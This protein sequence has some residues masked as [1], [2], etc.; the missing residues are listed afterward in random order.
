[1]GSERARGEG[2]VTSTARRIRGE[3]VAAFGRVMSVIATPVALVIE[4]SGE[5]DSAP[6]LF[7]PP[8]AGHEEMVRTLPARIGGC[9]RS[10]PGYVAAL[11]RHFDGQRPN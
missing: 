5:L 7:E 1:V 11:R 3:S 2:S 6:P 8:L 10:P 4:H 9:R